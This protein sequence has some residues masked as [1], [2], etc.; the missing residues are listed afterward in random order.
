MM[1]VKNLNVRDLDSVVN[2]SAWGPHPGPG[3]PGGPHGPGGPG[4]PHGPGGPGGP[5]GPGGPRRSYNEDKESL[6]TV[7]VLKLA[8]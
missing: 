8:A 1:T 5:H 2:V 7:K 6:D 4:G 3:G